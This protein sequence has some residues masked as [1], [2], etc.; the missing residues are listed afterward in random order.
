MSAWYLFASLGLYPE[1]PGSD[2]LV[3]ASPLHPRT[4]LHLAGGDVTI[5][6]EGGGP[7]APYVQRLTLNGRVW[8][9]PWLRFADL[10]HGGSL[11]FELGSQPDLEWGAKAADAPPSY[12]AP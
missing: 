1:L 11:A 2:V 9:K 5:T 7:D 12:D 10:A 3:L 6:G 8:T 4:V